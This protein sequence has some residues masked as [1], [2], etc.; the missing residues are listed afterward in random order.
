MSL[1]VFTGSVHPLSGNFYIVYRKDYKNDNIIRIVE[2]LLSDEGQ[3]MIE[4]CG[5]VKL[6]D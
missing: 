2:W 3:T 5:Y 6:P 1:Y 4:A